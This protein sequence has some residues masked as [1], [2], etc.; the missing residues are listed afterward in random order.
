MNMKKTKR[1]TMRFLLLVV[2]CFHLIA[3]SNCFKVV[4]AIGTKK[5][6]EVDKSA[7]N[8]VGRRGG[9]GGGHG[10]G[11]HSG[12]SHGSGSRGSGGYRGYH[13]I[14]VYA[15]GHQQAHHGRGNN[16]SSNSITISHL[17]STILAL[18][19]LFT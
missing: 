18:V 9:G 6:L 4:H 10:G 5:E 13:V 11:G 16:S 14:P 3:S 8:F 7:V 2:V 12:G 17:V 15:G 1:P 19:L